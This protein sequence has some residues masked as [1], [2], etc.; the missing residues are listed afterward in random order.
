MRVR[1]FVTLVQS[2]TGKMLPELDA[3]F[4]G[5][6]TRS[7]C[8]VICQISTVIMCLTVW[9]SRSSAVVSFDDMSKAPRQSVCLSGGE[10]TTVQIAILGWI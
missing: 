6:Q 7:S 10:S 8:R 5:R 3:I 9:S 1:T 2:S 4:G